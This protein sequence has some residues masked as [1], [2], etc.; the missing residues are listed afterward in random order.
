ME[1]LAPLSPVI[2]CDL[3]QLLQA[4]ADAFYLGYASSQPWGSEVLS[5]RQGI[6]ANYPDLEAACSAIENLAA[7]GRPA[8]VTLNEHFYQEA[9]L[10]AVLGDTDRLLEA[11]ARGF[12]VTDISLMMEI[13]RLYPRARIT[14]SCGA[15]IGNRQTVGF[16]RDLG[17]SGV[18]FPRHLALADMRAMV[19]AFPDVQFE[20]FVKNDR[21][22]NIDGMCR[23]VHGT[24][25]D[26]V[27]G[28]A[29]LNMRCR[30][31]G[32]SLES[33]EHAA[34][35][36][37]SLYELRGLSNLAMKICGRE[38][39]GQ[40]I[41]RDVRF[42]SL[43]RKELVADVARAGFEDHCRTAY[44]SIYGEPCNANC[45]HAK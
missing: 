45:Y 42:F 2:A 1:I 31:E 3:E 8:W 33:F 4:G 24:I 43:I 16:Y 37:C 30:S 13:R 29:C 32:G 25:A 23:F 36:A 22:P 28:Q 15:R 9:V 6:R 40:W 38:K 26:V 17:V 12:I 41:E 14:A 44:R 39:P 18:V 20:I 35:G 7:V 5:R 27:Y 21:C 19:S 11:G 10:R 34:C